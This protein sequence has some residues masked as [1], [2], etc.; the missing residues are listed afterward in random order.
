M[1]FSALCRLTLFCSLQY[2]PVTEYLF[3]Q[4]CQTMCLSCSDPGTLKNHAEQCTLGSPER[5]V[6]L[7][8]P[9]LCKDRLHVGVFNDV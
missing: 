4:L 6:G 3:I 1:H 5:G 7:N 9:S 2:R 8:L